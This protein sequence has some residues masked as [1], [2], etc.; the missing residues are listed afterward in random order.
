VRVTALGVDGHD[1]LSLKGLILKAMKLEHPATVGQLAKTVMARNIIDEGDFVTI[2]KEMASDGSLILEKPSYEIESIMDYLL[3]WTL[4]AWFWATL[5][6]TA[7]SVGVITSIPQLIPLNLLRIALASTF[8]LY[9]PG[10][11]LLQ[12]LHPNISQSDVLERFAL[13]VGVSLAVVPV[14]GL[15]LSFTPWGIRFGSIVASVGGIVVFSVIG[16]AIREY[17]ALRKRQGRAYPLT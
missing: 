4:S 9:L 13:R 16:A 8:V 2:V 3:T 7:L 17:F 14:I 12:F 11:S 6:V 5:A 10:F 15:V 1:Q